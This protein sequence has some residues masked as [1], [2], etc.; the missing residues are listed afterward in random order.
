VPD[1]FVLDMPVDFGL[2]FVAVIRP[3]FTDSERELFNDIVDEVDGIGLGVTSIDLE[4][5][6]AGRIIDGGVLVRPDVFTLLPMKVRNL[7][8][9]GIWWPGTCLL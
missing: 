7:M 3:D 4:C 2:E 5:P 1:A 8:S 6:D 9:T